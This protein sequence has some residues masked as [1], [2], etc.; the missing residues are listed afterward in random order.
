[1]L[2]AGVDPPKAPPLLPPD[3]RYKADLLLV[4]AHP[5]DDVL[6]GGYLAR[7]SLDEHKRT[8]VVYCTSGDGGGNA[9]GY[10]AGQSLGQMRILEARKALGFLGI[11][12]VWFLGGHDT[13]GQN[14][15]W[16]LDNWNH[17]RALDE[18][19]RLV[20][21]TRPEVVMTLLPAYTVGENHDD[22]QAAGVLATEAFDMAGDP[23]KF[24]EQVSAP[25]N[26][27]GMMNLTEGLHVWQPKKI[28]YATDAFENFS[29][30]WHDKE[31]LSP[32]RKNILD[33]TGPTYSTTEISS[34]KQ[35][36]YAKLAAEQQKYYL[37]QEAYL[38]REAFER[39]DFS[40][41][42]YPVR[43]ILGK[44]LVGGTKT[45]DVFEGITANSVPWARVREFQPQ[46]R[47]G[48]SL[49]IGGPWAFYP[50]F[51]KAHDLENLAE[52]LPVPEVSI[53][54]GKVL[55]I[56]LLLHNDGT[57]P[58]EVKLTSVFPSGWTDRTPYVLY[59]LNP[60]ES[61]PVL[62][63]AVAP[64]STDHRL[65][66]ITWKAEARGKQIGSITMRVH[67]SKEGGLPQ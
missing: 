20:R 62:A 38:G 60:D 46:I 29:P 10:E 24:P 56:P 4:L 15:L 55:N 53:Q 65:Q 25:R 3:D 51:W 67:V 19:V 41:F 12:N 50:E 43:L 17:G 57:T 5:D 48:L 54:F 8:A 2:L 37:T 64:E 31:D 52:L 9:V 26:R 45:G 11:E 44:S 23:T 66:E 49:E 16:S 13:P 35:K 14:V 59:P 39:D 58:A 34:S 21:L 7:I 22:H 42:E 28:Y 63:T 61:Y 47:K 6:I 30:Y 18:V 33:G 40:G 27:V 32:F 1:M 36:T